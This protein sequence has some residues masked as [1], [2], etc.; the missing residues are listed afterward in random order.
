M[1]LKKRVVEAQWEEFGYPLEGKILLLPLTGARIAK[2]EK[3]VGAQPHGVRFD[4]GDGK[5]PES[6]YIQ[7]SL[8][9]DRKRKA[10]IDLLKDIVMNVNIEYEDGEKVP[11]DKDVYDLLLD[12]ESFDQ[13]YIRAKRLG[14]VR[15]AEAEKN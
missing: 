5:E 11:F 10:D 1:A 6:R 8:D 14:S 12:A 7:I 15:T 9:P 2:Y 3:Q 13:I 4:H